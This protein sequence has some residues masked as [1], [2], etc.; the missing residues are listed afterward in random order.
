VS[1][2]ERKTRHRAAD[3]R[4]SVDL[5]RQADAAER[6]AIAGMTMAERMYLAFEL[7]EFATRNAGA[8]RR[9]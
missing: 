4:K 1:A 8:A 5:M 2:L 6:K 9:R 3:R 7:S